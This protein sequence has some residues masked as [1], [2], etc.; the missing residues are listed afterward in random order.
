MINQKARSVALDGPQVQCN[1]GLF[2][3]TQRSSHIEANNVSVLKTYEN[4]ID[5]L[6]TL[7]MANWRWPYMRTSPI[8]VADGITLIFLYGFSR[9]MHTRVI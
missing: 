5:L 8:C 6:V 1:I 4:L 9:S 3:L 7:Q 2:D